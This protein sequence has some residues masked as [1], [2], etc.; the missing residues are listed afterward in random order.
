MEEESPLRE[1]QKL[2]IRA[3]NFL[4]EEKSFVKSLNAFLDKM[5]ELSKEMRRADAA[6]GDRRDE[7]LRLRME[8]FEALSDAL[9]RQ[10]RV[11]HERSHLPESLGVLLAATEKEFQRILR[12]KE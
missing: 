4:E 2:R 10:G 9:S 1:V 7:L 11:E 8:A 6:S 3:K 12:K 5:E